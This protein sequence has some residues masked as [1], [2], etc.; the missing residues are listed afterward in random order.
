MASPP[1]PARIQSEPATRA[2]AS[3][4]SPDLSL[5]TMGP[6]V[7]GWPQPFVLLAEFADNALVFELRAFLRNVEKRVRVA[8][9]L[10][11]AIDR[12]CRDAGIAYPSTQS[13]IHLRDI[14]RLERALSRLAAQPEAGTPAARSRPR[15]IR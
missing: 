15:R 13:E 9:D 10:R 3:T 7:L 2:R 5:P 1:R 14:E 12:A 4:L 11:F 6:E 8:S